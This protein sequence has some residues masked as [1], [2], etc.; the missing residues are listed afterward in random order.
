MFSKLVESQNERALAIPILPTSADKGD[1]ALVAAAQRGDGQA[2]ETLVR[3][4]QHFVR[5]IAR[6][7]TRVEE[8][9]ED[10]VQQSLQ[11][12]F[13]HL[14]Q[15]EGNSSFS[16]WVTRIAINEALI[17]LRKRRASREVPIEKWDAE[18][19]Q[20]LLLDP[21]D[22][23]PTPEDRYLQREQKQILSQAMKTL[24]PA[25]RRAIELRDLGELSTHETA[26]VMGLTVGAVKA[27]IFHGRRKLRVMLKRYAESACP[28]GRRAIPM[29]SKVKACNA[30]DLDGPQSLNG[31]L[32]LNE[33]SRRVPICKR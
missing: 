28:R 1:A 11:K 14:H 18:N 12:A 27:R 15:F 16:T 33:S 23:R 4:H 19:G 8:D 30:R 3:R 29:S 9:A 2:F 7:F 10:V 17:C 32:R 22:P 5:V 31:V 6:R 21:L 26:G 20:T 24:A 25:V 13:I